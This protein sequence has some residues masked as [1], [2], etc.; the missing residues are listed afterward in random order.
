MKT[1][2]YNTKGVCSRSIDIELDDENIIR[3]IKFEGGCNGNLQ[4]VSKLAVGRKAEE[5]IA[6]IAGTKC[7]RKDTSCPD[8]LSIALRSMLQAQ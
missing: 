5:V 6:L 2:H 3:S 4:G 7:G 8:Q 1:L